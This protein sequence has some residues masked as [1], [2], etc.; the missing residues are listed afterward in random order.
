M[1]IQ[2]NN[3]PNFSARAE[4]HNHFQNRLYLEE[5][6]NEPELSVD[7]RGIAWEVPE[8][9]KGY[10]YELLREGCDNRMH[11]KASANYLDVLSIGIRH[12]NGD[13]ITPHVEIFHKR[14]FDSPSGFYSSTDRQVHHNGELED[15]NN[16][17]GSL[18]KL[19]H[20]M[21]TQFEINLIQRQLK[22]DV[23]SLSP[24]QLV[25]GVQ[26][27]VNILGYEMVKRK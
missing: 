14:E 15:G 26:R 13:V 11:D 27:L 6:N 21:R 7:A 19:I 20:Q 18:R 10:Y 23:A 22:D 1:K 8:L 16:I 12:E 5:W 3:S 25:D 24:Q 2:N 4:Y 9:P 17:L